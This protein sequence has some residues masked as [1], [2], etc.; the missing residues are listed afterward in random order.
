MGRT[1]RSIAC[2]CSIALLPFFSPIA[3]EAAPTCFGKR[4]TKVQRGNDQFYDYWIGTKKADVIII[5]DYTPKGERDILVAGKGGDDLICG[6]NHRS[7]FADI[8]G[9]DGND[10]IEV[11]PNRD[12]SGIGGAGNDELT[13]GKGRNRLLGGAGDD[14]LEG[15]GGNDDLFGDADIDS[16]QDVPR[17]AGSGK[18]VLLGGPG[19]DSLDG[20]DGDDELDAGTGKDD[21]NGWNGNDTLRSGALDGQIDVVLGFEGDDLIVDGDEGSYLIGGRGSDDIRAGGGDDTIHAD[22]DEECNNSDQGSLPDLVDAGPGNDWIS[23][24]DDDEMG[25]EIHSGSGDDKVLGYGDSAQIFGDDGDDEL[26]GS[27][28][29]LLDGG[30]GHDYLMRG[31]TCVNGERFDECGSTQG[32]DW[33]DLRTWQQQGDKP[34]DSFPDWVFPTSKPPVGNWGRAIP[35]E[36]FTPTFFVGPDSYSTVTVKGYAGP[37]TNEEAYAGLVLGYNAPTGAANGPCS[38]GPCELDMVLLDWGR[39]DAASP[40][41]VSLVRVTGT[42]NLRDEPSLRDSFWMHVDSANFDVI[43]TQSKL[44]ELDGAGYALFTV[45]YSLDRVLVTQRDF[46]LETTTVLDVTG[47]FPSGRVGLYDIGGSSTFHGIAVYSD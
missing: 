44:G 34:T 25:D 5:P 18:D 42:F 20:G 10:R 11:G 8:F 43:A 30:P 7:R 1:S 41:Q 29:G 45:T 36:N 15:N 46:E 38:T 27:W 39:G 22:C 35:D 13:G 33:I 47:T 2:F 40:D 6:G 17:S 26:S 12:S 31:D 21:L 28:G 16:P 24:G 4:A 32:G 9:G 37:E 19:N 14:V 3:A 23:A